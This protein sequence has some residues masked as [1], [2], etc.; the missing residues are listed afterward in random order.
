[1]KVP[2]MGASAVEAVEILS[3]PFTLGEDDAVKQQ[4]AQNLKARSSP[5]RIHVW[6][7]WKKKKIRYCKIKILDDSWLIGRFR[8]EKLDG[9]WWNHSESNQTKHTRGAD[10]ARPLHI[11]A[12]PVGGYCQAGRRRGSNMHVATFHSKYHTTPDNTRRTLRKAQLIIEIIMQAV[13]H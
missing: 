10:Y 2:A 6:D 7:E 4:N 3:P 9:I 11:P 13:K 12:S 8:D 5:E 1:M